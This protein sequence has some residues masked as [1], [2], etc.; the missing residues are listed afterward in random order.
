MKRTIR[1]RLGPTREQADALLET[2]RQHTE[3]FNAVCA[4][5]PIHPRLGTT[6]APIRFAPPRA[7]WASPPWQDGSRCRSPRKTR[8]DRRTGAARW[9]PLSVVPLLPFCA[10]VMRSTTGSRQAVYRV[11]ETQRKEVR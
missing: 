6:P 5:G 2:L 11:A 8:G 9:H 3:C 1:L 10:C 7:M 4:Y